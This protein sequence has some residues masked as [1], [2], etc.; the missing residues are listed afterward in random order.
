MWEQ[1]HRGGGG[2]GGRIQRQPEN[3]RRSCRLSCCLHRLW[4]LLLQVAC[5]TCF[6]S[7]IKAVLM[8]CLFVC[9][10]Q[11][12]LRFNIF[13][14]HPPQSISSLC[15]IRSTFQLLRRRSLLLQ[16]ILLH[17]H[18]NADNWVWWHRARY[19]EHCWGVDLRWVI[20]LI[21]FQTL[22][23]VRTLSYPQTVKCTN[24]H[25]HNDIR[26]CTKQSLH[27]VYG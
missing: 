4:C 13:A 23:A 22:S 8:S 15:C 26:K 14:V 2:A 20:I 25:F 21:F 18:N 24:Y 1:G 11:E 12:N 5:S 16:C 17:L 19:R 9:W 7:L 27:I 3:R 6:S 10:L